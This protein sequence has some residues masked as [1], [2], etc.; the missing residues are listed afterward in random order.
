MPQLRRDPIT[1]RWVIIAAE[2][3]KRP[4][5]FLSKQEQMIDNGC[6]FCKGSED[7]TPSEIFA[8]REAGTKPNQPGWSV[9]VV[10]SIA[11]ILR[12]EGKLN[13]HGKGMYD[14]MN[15]VGAHEIV[16]ET[17]EH[18]AHLSELPPEHIKKV[19]DTYISRMLDLEK[20]TR[21]KYVL[22]FKNY[23]IAAG[24]SMYKHS[25][26]Q[27][28][29]TPV[30]P[31]LVKEELAGAKKYFDYKN[32]CV[33]CDMVKQE[34]DSQERIILETDGFVAIAPYASRF[35]FE[36]CILPKDHN[37]DFPDISDGSRFDL[38]RV[39][40]IVLTK[41]KAALG[42]P[43]YNFMIHTAPFRV[44]RKAG[45]WKT[46]EDDYHWHIEII[47]RLTRVAGFEWGAGV[48]INPT[49][50]EEAAKYLRGLDI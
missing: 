22:I 47:P 39:M 26:S 1:E 4:E 27:L 38:A 34:L 10:P 36:V 44:G 48:Y 14:L 35:P 45:Y 24:S 23:G 49:P 41:L 13:R 28:I 8:I 40:K 18:I 7:K 21:F 42:D 50:P 20:D 31:K 16:I 29:A 6:P 15:G 30:N 17:P 37:C 33:F 12:V 43:P 2:R 9:R 25:R 3:A 5:D 19:I 46:I 32:R 11:P